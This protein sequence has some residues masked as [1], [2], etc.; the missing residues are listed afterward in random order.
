MFTPG[1]RA[2]AYKSASGLGKW[3]NRDPIGEAGFELVAARPEWRAAILRQ[4]MFAMLKTLQITKS[5]WPNHQENAN[6]GTLS[7]PLNVYAF[8]QN[9]PIIQFD[10][11]GLMTEQEF[12]QWWF[13]LQAKA[14]LAIGAIDIAERLYI[15]HNLKQGESYVTQT[16]G[17]RVISIPVLPFLEMMGDIIELQITKYGNSC[18]DCLY[19]FV[20]V[21]INGNNSA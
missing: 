11:N 9:D 8:C 5:S 13:G 16:A 10:Q 1:L 14:G 20:L 21:P 15:C 19:K 6:L 12:F 4:R 2:C 18:L 7:L 17:T 3:P